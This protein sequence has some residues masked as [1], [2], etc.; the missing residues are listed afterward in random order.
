MVILMPLFGSVAN[1][2]KAKA[3]TPSQA[4]TPLIVSQASGQ[5]QISW[6]D[7][8]FSGGAPITDYKIEYSSNS[9]SS[10]STW[11][12]TPSISTSATVTGLTDFLTYIFRVSAVNAVGNGIASGNS[13]DAIQSSL[14]TGGSESTISNYNGTG[15]T[16]KVHQFTSN[17]TFNISRSLN[18][19]KV[20]VVGGGAGAMGENNQA[21]GNAGAGAGTGTDSLITLSPG[22]YSITVGAGGAGT[23]FGYTY[24]AG[25]TAGSSSFAGT[26]NGPGGGSPGSGYGGWNYTSTTTGTSLLCGKSP[27][28]VSTTG[29]IGGQFPGGGGGACDGPGGYCGGASGAG[30]LVAISYRIS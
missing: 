26:Y 23:Y 10:W 14:G 30:G 1:H 18:Q 8:S 6:T 24:Y 7:P 5:V 17:G 22:N 29:G 20:L 12:H 9:G 13:S 16:W 2:G 27:A 28:G 3:T 11:S 4:G 25:T 21:I 15:Q 19:F